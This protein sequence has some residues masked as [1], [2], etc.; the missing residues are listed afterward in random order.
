MLL[1]AFREGEGPVA[2]AELAQRAGLARS[3]AH[4][5]LGILAA[6]GFVESRGDGTYQVGIKVWEI[7]LRS[8]RP[9]GLLGF[10]QPFLERLA[11]CSEETVHLSVRDGV[12]AI[13]VA[14]IA[15]PQR[16]AAQTHLGQ[17]VPLYCTATGKALLAF[18][19]LEVVDEVLAGPL[20]AYTPLTVTDPDEIRAEL[21]RTRAR[22]YAVN[23][24]QHHLE[25]GGVAAAV[26]GSRQEVLAAFGIA[27]PVYRFGE[28]R[29]AELGEL[30][31]T[32]AAEAS[33]TAFVP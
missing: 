31:R 5:L 4:R 3:T 30:V 17:R 9:G 12:Q 20:R 2:L 6:R 8:M 24:G 10:A 18:S 25:T 1:E 32:V 33:R 23:M 21:E 22:G 13:Y 16:V 28:D 15:S 7:G 29:T 11:A 27:G 14:R 19:P 26:F